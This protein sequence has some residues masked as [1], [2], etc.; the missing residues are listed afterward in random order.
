MLHFVHQL[1]TSF[2]Y[3]RFGTEQVICDWFENSEIEPNQ[4]CCGPE[5]QNNKQQAER[6][7]IYQMGN[8]E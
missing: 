4:L 3:L 1:V 2:V 8:T 7:L 6:C 5:N